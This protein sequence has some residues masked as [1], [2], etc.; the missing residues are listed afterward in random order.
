MSIFQS[1]DL[2][3]TRRPNSESLSLF[4]SSVT[5]GVVLVRLIPLLLSGHLARD[6][7]GKT[8]AAYIPSMSYSIEFST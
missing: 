5:E 1:T 7:E 8:K 6:N 3:A 4:V 2:R